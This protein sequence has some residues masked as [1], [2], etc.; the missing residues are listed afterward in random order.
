MM[1]TAIACVRAADLLVIIGTSLAVCPAASLIEYAPSRT[2]IFLIDPEP[3][4][5]PGA[6]VTV[7][8]AGASEGVA[9]LKA[10]L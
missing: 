1:E 5:I 2:Q 8:R 6:R 9:R 7:I 3:P 4:E 10:L